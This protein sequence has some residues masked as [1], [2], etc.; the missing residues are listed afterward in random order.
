MPAVAPG[1]ARS[2]LD[3][4]AWAQV[5][6]DVPPPVRMFR[7]VMMHEQDD[8]EALDDA[9]ATLG[10]TSAWRWG[11]AA[12]RSED[13][14]R[15]AV[16][17]R[18]WLAAAR[19]GGALLDRFGIALA[20]L[21]TTM[22]MSGEMPALGTRGR[23]SIVLLPVAPPA[24]V[25]RGWMWAIDPG[26]VLGLLFA[27]VGGTNIQRGTVVLA[28]AG[29]SQPDRGPPLPCRI[30]T[31]SAGEIDVVCTP[32]TDGYAV[33][34]STP[35]AGWE[36]TVDGHE[37]DWLAAD[38]LRRAVHID[39]GMHHVHWTYVTPGLR[40]GA[41]AAACGVLAVVGLWLASR[42]RVS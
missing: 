6:E 28:G 35:V 29:R 12:A 7:P 36:V 1:I 18:V 15:L 20:I 17:D 21:P 11:I 40:T 31:W 2:T 34:S 30:Q 4:P 41:I 19:E 3:E 33:V 22:T 9:I 27:P 13:P 39:A 14:A 8:A 42:R 10:G 25:L 38:L 26:D 32:D 24:A 5:G 23:W 37:A 16:H